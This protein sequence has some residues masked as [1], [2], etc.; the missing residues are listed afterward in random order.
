MLM[1][2]MEKAKRQGTSGKRE[3]ER[4]KRKANAA[5][6]YGEGKKIRNKWKKRI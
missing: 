3:F 6:D 4:G 5:D 2:I 1:M